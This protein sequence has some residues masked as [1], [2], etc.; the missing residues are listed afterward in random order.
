MRRPSDSSKHSPSWRPVAYWSRMAR[1]RGDTRRSCRRGWLIRVTGDG[2]S[3]GASRRDSASECAAP[4]RA[5]EG[6]GRK[7]HAE[8][9]PRPRLRRCRPQ[10]GEGWGCDTVR[11]RS[12]ASR[13]PGPRRHGR[14]R[15]RMRPGRKTIRWTR[16]P[17]QPTGTVTRA[18]N[19]QTIEEACAASD[20][21]I[22]CRLST[23]WPGLLPRQRL[24]HPVPD[25][26]RGKPLDHV[27][28]PVAGRGGELAARRR[29]EALQR[30][31]QSRPVSR[32]HQP[33]VGP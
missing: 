27:P 33:A 21:A 32:R 28:L 9:L 8:R 26:A 13:G 12:A 11:R 15:V 3:S 31:R 10:R 17:C 2:V 23:A 5:R 19:P 6:A 4:P 24:A 30:A 18:C 20:S 16:S 14:V 1:R 7:E 22:P 29:H 25:D